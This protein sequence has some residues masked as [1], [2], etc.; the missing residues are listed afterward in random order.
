[1]SINVE[2]NIEILIARDATPDA[3]PYLRARK[4][5]N[6]PKDV[7]GL[8]ILDVG[9]SGS[10]LSAN[11]IRSGAN[12]Y[13]IDPAYE[14]I[15]A[16]YQ[17]IRKGLTPQFYPPTEIKLIQQT[18]IDFMDSAKKHPKRYIAGYASDMSM[19]ADN[20]FDIITSINTLTAYLD[21]NAPI[22]NKSFNE[23]L[24][25]LRPGGVILSVPFLKQNPYDNAFRNQIRIFNNQGLLK[26]LDENPAVAAVEIVENGFNKEL[27]LK[28]TKAVASE[29][30]QQESQPSQE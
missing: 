8:N 28:V 10:N 3:I 5:L 21:V 13:S 23:C 16:M 6:L 29:S 7:K 24:K 14:N 25:K 15:P 19:F 9:G 30:P 11:L 4:I 17:R 27:M 26:V 20:L 12:A 22:L 2:R 18:L 1:M